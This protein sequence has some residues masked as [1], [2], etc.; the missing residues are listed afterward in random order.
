MLGTTVI[1]IILWSDI[2]VSSLDQ[3]KTSVPRVRVMSGEL[4]FVSKMSNCSRLRE[5]DRVGRVGLFSIV[6]SFVWIQPMRASALLLSDSCSSFE[7][8]YQCDECV[9]KSPPM[10]TGPSLE[11]A[12]CRSSMWCSRLAGGGTKTEAARWY[13][14]VIISQ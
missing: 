2:V 8:R 9:L 11:T 1:V 12:L 3:S 14:L 10:T 6:R 7:P 5:T 13:Y 4:C